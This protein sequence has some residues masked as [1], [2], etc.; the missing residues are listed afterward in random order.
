MADVQDLVAPSR[1]GRSLEGQEL[2]GLIGGRRGLRSRVAAGGRTG[3]TGIIEA[4][5]IPR[6]L[7]A[8][9]AE[10]RGPSLPAFQ[11]ADPSRREV[12]ALA[13]QTLVEDV[14]GICARVE[15]LR[16]EGRSLEAIY[17]QVLGPAAGH[18]RLLWSEDLCGFA[19][20]TLALWR[21]QQVLREYSVTFQGEAP[22]QE[23][24]RRA[25]LVPSPGEKHDL[26]FVMF[27]LVMMSQFLRRDGWEAWIEPDASTPECAA[28]VRSQ[29]F[30]IVEFLVSGDKQLDALAAGIRTIR[31][32]SPNP[33]VGIIV[34]GQVFIEHP[35]LVLPLGADLTAAD[36]RQGALK[37]EGLARM[38]ASRLPV[39]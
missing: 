28:V 10:P 39:R 32:D 36:A 29:W 5:I 3:L 2:S 15:K 9:N 31:R 24:G 23:T 18:L 27:G 11:R 17:T 19:E 1:F 13:E 34:C 25:L 35:E 16:A 26:S 12:T 30:D 22:R 7:A 37:A 38:R 4:E 14:E 20:V 33:S 21:L 6:L 8:H